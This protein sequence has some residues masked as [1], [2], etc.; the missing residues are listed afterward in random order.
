MRLYFNEND[1]SVSHSLSVFVFCINTIIIIMVSVYTA[2]SNVCLY[3][4]KLITTLLQ[5]FC[6]E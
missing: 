5:L 4:F 2:C 3:R 1:S 6:F